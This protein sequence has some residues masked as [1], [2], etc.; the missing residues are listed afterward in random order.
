MNTVT[1]WMRLCLKRYVLN[2][3][4]LDFFFA[5]FAVKSFLTAKDT[6]DYAKSTEKLILLEVPTKQTE[7]NAHRVRFTEPVTSVRESFGYSLACVT[8]S[9]NSFHPGALGR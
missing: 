1:G 4:K 6:R 2:G 9:V 3:V 5:N 7:P 8:G